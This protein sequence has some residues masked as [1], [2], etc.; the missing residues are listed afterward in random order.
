MNQT[1][2]NKSGINNGATTKVVG[3][4]KWELEIVHVNVVC[5]SKVCVNIE[6]A[7]ELEIVA[8]VGLKYAM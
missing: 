3:L 4:S 7:V 5:L 2:R 1:T 6:V 8:S